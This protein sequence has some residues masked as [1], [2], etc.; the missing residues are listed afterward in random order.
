MVNNEILDG[1]KSAI[2]RGETIKQATISFLNAG[3]D[4]LEVQEASKELE[5]GNSFFSSI[6]KK[7]ISSKKPSLNNNQASVIKKAISL[8][9]ISEKNKSSPS[10]SNSQNSQQLQ[11]S[12]QLQTNSSQ[13][14]PLSQTTSQNPTNS[15]QNYPSQQQNPQQFQ[16]PS[17]Q[18]NPQQFQTNSPQNYPSQQQNLQNNFS[19]TQRDSFQNQEYPHLPLISENRVQNKTPPSFEK[20]FNNQVQR[21]S[22]S[23]QNSQQFQTSSQLQEN[24]SQSIPNSQQSFLPQQNNSQN[25]EEFRITPSQN[26]PQLQTNSLPPQSQPNSSQKNSIQNS[27]IISKNKSENLNA[28]EQK[29]LEKN[30]QEKNSFSKTNNGN[31]MKDNLPNKKES[32]IQKVSRYDSTPND[33]GRKIL[34]FGL[35]ALLIILLGGLA[36]IFFFQDSFISFLK[37]I[38]S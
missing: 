25:S 32:S 37:G 18:Q 12:F 15:S 11:T 29:K 10:T 23:L 5:K 17:Q 22:S 26:P 7:V 38:F 31:T 9:D 34:I 36:F 3:Y 35:I 33:T 8:P 19:N 20:Y 2:S 14:S 27:P 1:L 30:S 24:I 16:T 28:N 4:P 6:P 21:N 13:N